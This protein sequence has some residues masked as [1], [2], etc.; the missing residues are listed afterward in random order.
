MR[1]RA[2]S[3]A[4]VPTADDRAGGESIPTLASILRARVYDVAI[5]SPLEPAQRLSQQ[6]GQPVLL[7]REDLQPVFSFKLRGAYNRMSSLSR[8]EQ[9]RGVICSSAGNH[10]QGVALAAQRLGIAATVVMPTTTPEIKVEAV[11]RLG[12]SIVLCGD[13]Y[14]DAQDEAHR[15]ADD[16]RLT[17]IHPFDDADVIAGQ[18]TIGM[19]LLRQCNPPPAAV[20]VPIGGGG[21]AAGVALYVKTVRPETQVVGV[22]PHDSASMTAALAAGEPV[23]LDHVGTFADGVAVRR[24]GDITFRLCRQHLDRIVRVD[25]DQICSA[26]R[27]VFRDTRSIAEPAGALALAGLLQDDSRPPGPLVALNCGANVN[28]DRLR[29]VAER[30]DIGAQREALLG[31]EIPERAGSFLAFCRALGERQVTEFNYRF[32][33]PGTARIFVGV[34]TGGR[35][36]TRQLVGSLEAAGYR[37]TD[38]SADAMAKTH[39]RYMVGGTASLD[40]EMLFRFEFPERRGAL[41][42]FLEKVGVRWNI[43]LFHYRNHGSDFGRVLVGIQIPQ[44]D[45][46]QLADHLQQVGYPY[47]NESENPAYALFLAGRGDAAS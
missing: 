35:E 8:E 45:R 3:V 12:G 6:L 41:L 1:K 16:E 42:R 14:D 10:A 36:V 25:T 40:D 39:V 19:E 2:A 30:A 13:T 24:V 46:S 33:G 17:F 31:V 47:W 5:E 32:S 7:K 29:H 15:R 11:Q 9:E 23:T 22:E 34:E 44:E 43:S 27:D 26:I 18:G 28:F 21:L 20:Y 4:A 38:L 37:T